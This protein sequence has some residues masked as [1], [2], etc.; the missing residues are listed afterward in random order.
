[1]PLEGQIKKLFAELAKINR[2]LDGIDAS[3]EETKKAMKSVAADSRVVVSTVQAHGGV[4]EKLERSLT[5]LDLRCPLMKPDTS[6]FLKVEG[7]NSDR[8]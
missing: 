7:G 5:R 3:G 4:I 1:M 2:R 8:G 6:E